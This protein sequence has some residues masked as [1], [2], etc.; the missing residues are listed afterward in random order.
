V[1]FLQAESLETGVFFAVLNFSSVFFESGVRRHL[2]IR[3]E[4]PD[5]AIGNMPLSELQSDFHP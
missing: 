4:T 2:V 3:R 1:H 5:E